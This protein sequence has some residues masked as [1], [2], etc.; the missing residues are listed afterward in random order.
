MSRKSGEVDPLD[1]VLS[2]Q[3]P[4]LCGTVKRTHD[5]CDGDWTQQL[6]MEAMPDGRFRIYC[7]YPAYQEAEDTFEPALTKYCVL[8]RW[9]E[10]P[11]WLL[12]CALRVSEESC[13]QKEGSPLPLPSLPEMEKPFR[14]LLDVLPWPPDL[15]TMVGYTVVSEDNP[16]VS[17]VIGI[18]PDGDARVLVGE[19]YEEYRFRNS[20]FGGGMSVP[21]RNALVVMA[22]AIRRHHQT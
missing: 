21:V 22:E 13:P 14:D 6:L 3:V 11:A 9:L 16:E 4:R 20:F 2:W 7:R 8:P 17:W 5:D 12:W 15:E 10:G 18:S 1:Y 19:M